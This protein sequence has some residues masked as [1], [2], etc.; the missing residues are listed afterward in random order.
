M[1]PSTIGYIIRQGF[2][3]IRRNWMF[4]IAS[5]LTMAACIFLFGVFYSIVDNV[6]YNTQRMEEEIPIKVFF[7]EGTSQEE[8][9]RIGE[10]I[11]TRPEVVSI[12]YES[13]DEGWAKYQEDYFGDD[14]DVAAAF[15]QD[16]KDDNPL[17]NSSNYQV[18]VRDIEAQ[19]DL[20]AFI[21]G[22]EHVRKVNYM[23][24]A[25]KTLGSINRVIYVTSIVIL[26]ILLLISVFLISNTVAIGVSVRKEEIGIMKYIGATDRFVRAP[27]I[28]EG[29]LLGLVGAA[30]PLIGLYFLYSDT[31]QYILQKYSA[32]S[33]AVYFLS[34]D[35]EF[36]LLGPIGL[37]LGIGVGLIGSIWTTSRHVR[38]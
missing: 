20:V 10:Q 5:I 14:P 19:G 18:T 33:G 1:R 8:I 3:N 31:V 15:L 23:E 16:F 26:G 11:R 29:I 25:V 9:E 28:L 21:E 32:L 37:L 30:I 38:V 13:A 24:N 6:N 12:E 4:S 7:E 22:L 36:R 27:F 35:Q 2:K 17:E 34:V